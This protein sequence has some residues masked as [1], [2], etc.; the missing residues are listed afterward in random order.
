MF[1]FCISVCP[2]YAL[3]REL[4]FPPIKCRGKRHATLR[5]QVDLFDVC[6]R[7]PD[8]FNICNSYIKRANLERF[9]LFFSKHR[10]SLVSLVTGF[11][12]ISSQQWPYNVDAGRIVATPETL[13]EQCFQTM[14]K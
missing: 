14:V 13:S 5:V 11:R 6:P 10:T 4:G 12:V 1:C 8:P 2:V 9:F 7:V 3:R